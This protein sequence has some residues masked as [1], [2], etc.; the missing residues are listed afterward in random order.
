MRGMQEERRLEMRSGQKPLFL[1]NYGYEWEI[2]ML[3]IDKS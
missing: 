1:L 2:G 3:M